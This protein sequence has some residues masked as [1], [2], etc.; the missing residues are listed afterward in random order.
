M[1]DSSKRKAESR[2]PIMSLSMVGDADLTLDGGVGREL[3]W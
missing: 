1:G 2:S 3:R